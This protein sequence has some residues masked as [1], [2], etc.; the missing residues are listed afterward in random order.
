[1]PKNRNNNNG[2]NSGIASQSVISGNKI[3][4]VASFYSN[5]QVLI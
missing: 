3:R 1:M 4:Q 5:S 2:N